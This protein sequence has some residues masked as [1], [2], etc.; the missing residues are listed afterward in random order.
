MYKHHHNLLPL[1]FGDLFCLN[2]NTHSYY[3]RRSNQSINQSINL[4]N[5][6]RQHKCNKQLY[7]EYT[8]RK[9]SL[10]KSVLDRQYVRQDVLEM[11]AVIQ[12]V[13]WSCHW[14]HRQSTVGYPC[15]V[16]CTWSGSKWL[17][18][19]CLTALLVHKIFLNLKLSVHRNLTVLVCTFAVWF[20]IKLQQ[21]FLLLC[22]YRLL[23]RC[24]T[25]NSRT[26]SACRKSVIKI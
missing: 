21:T 4:Y 11:W 25:V 12:Q 22:S 1:L 7:K 13:H 9:R 14:I 3:T 24:A 26:H 6:K 18:T 17:L 5:A 16:G 2:A 19:F 10:H 8:E 20:A 23:W 15:C